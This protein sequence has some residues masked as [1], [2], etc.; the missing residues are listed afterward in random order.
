MSNTGSVERSV[1]Q[2]AHGIPRARLVDP[3]L[4]ARPSLVILSAP[5]G[6]GKTVVAAQ[7]ALRAEFPKFA[8]V[9]GAGS[10]SVGDDM[11]QAAIVIGGLQPSAVALSEAEQQA[12]LQSALRELLDDQPVLVVFDDVEWVGDPGALATLEAALGDAPDGSVAV[13]TTRFEC[14][15]GVVHRGSWVLEPAQLALTDSEI[16]EL[17]E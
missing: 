4:D 3:V 13:V 7:V 11:W 8:W 6:Y 5:S 12:A 15:D 1:R 10:S 17:W 9:T 16:S 2:L 14:R